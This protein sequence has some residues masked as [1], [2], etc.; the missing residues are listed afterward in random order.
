MPSPFPSLAAWWLHNAWS[1]CKRHKPAVICQ[2]S[3][4]LSQKVQ[5]AGS[6]QMG[7]I[8]KLTKQ[9][10]LS[11]YDESWSY[12]RATTYKVQHLCL[13]GR[14]ELAPWP[15]ERS[16]AEAPAVWPTSE[17][18]M[19]DKDLRDRGIG[20]ESPGRW[21]LPTR[22]EQIKWIKNQN[23]KK[24]KFTT[25]QKTQYR[26]IKIALFT[27]LEASKISFGGWYP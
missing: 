13:Q 19:V 6:P 26:D 2:S 11:P 9:K 21:Q 5:E 4:S 22:G 27:S 20:T 16:P 18:K 17:L 14:L 3:G 1:Y 8:V 10:E 15:R 7:G 12:T 23:L 24:L 25:I